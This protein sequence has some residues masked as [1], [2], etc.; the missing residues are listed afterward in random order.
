MAWKTFSTRQGEQISYQVL[1]E[2]LVTRTQYQRL[3]I[4]DT[5]PFGR[6]LFLD[7]KIQSAETDEFLYHESLAHPA[8]V[9]HPS[10]RSVLIIGSGEGALLREV[11]KHNTVKR[12][13]MVD[14]DEEVVRACRE[15]LTQWHQGAFRDHRVEVLHVDARAYL[16]ETADV[17]D[18]ILVDVTDPLAGGPS[19]RIFTKEFYQLA[20]SHLSS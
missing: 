18:S 4:L 20:F 3:E 13:L 16:E 10:P 9:A 7:D 2:V 1:R 19:Y 5:L 12:V 14:I 15:H 11:L 8:L 17:F 6:C